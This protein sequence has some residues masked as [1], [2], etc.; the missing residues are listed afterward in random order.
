[1]DKYPIAEKFKAP[2][3][4]GI[5]TGTPMAFIRFVGCSV[6]KQI[7]KNCDTDFER[8]SV[9]LGGGVFST[10]D[11]SNWAYPFE[12]I[13]LTGGE[14][15]DR[16]LSTLVD[17][18]LYTRWLKTIHIETS[19]TKPIPKWVYDG[20][21]T[22]STWLTV[23]PKPGYRQDAIVA[24]DEIKVILHGLGDNEDGWPTIKDALKWAE[25]GIP[26]Y[27]QP[28]NDKLMVNKNHMEEALSVVMEH[29][30]LR[31]S[32]QLHKYLRTR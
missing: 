2:Q 32:C 19:G 4:E 30:Q 18:F 6:G 14:P 16:D 10:N 26:V 12:H 7:C 23:S 3:G 28:C 9:G 25:H 29:P 1:M 11:L 17:H 24:A 15:L 21:T 22:K 8:I 31:L 5:Y 27:I 13:C 20:N